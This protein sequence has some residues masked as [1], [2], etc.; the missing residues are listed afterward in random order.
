MVS[1]ILP[2]SVSLEELARMTVGKEVISVVPRKTVSGKII[3]QLQK[4]SAMGDREIPALSNLS[5][6]V[7]EGEIV[8][9][10]VWRKWTERIGGSNSGFTSGYRRACFLT[11]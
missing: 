2:S 4:V 10:Q 9:W 11:R 8:G 5:L 3:L 1:T 6:T 7:R